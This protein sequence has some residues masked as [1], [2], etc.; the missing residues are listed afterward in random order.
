V[1][2][3]RVQRR[4]G[5]RDLDRGRRTEAHHLA[6]EVRRFEGHAGPGHELGN[7]SAQFFRKR[8]GRDP[9]AFLELHQ[10][11]GLVRTAGPEKDQVHRIRGRLDAHEGERSGHVLRP[12]FLGDETE[13]VPDEA[14]GALHPGPGGRAQAHLHETGFDAGKDFGAEKR[15]QERDEDAARREVSRQDGALLRESSSGPDRVALLEPLHD[16]VP[17][18][19]ALSR[20]VS[21][22]LQPRLHHRHERAREEE[23]GHHG[24]S[25]RER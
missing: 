20:L 7:P 12:H 22:A 21:L 8:R 15:R 25:H 24:E 17:P 14:L 10:E 18:A 19:P 2:S 23:R 3:V 11:N 13:N 16:L 9:G 6:H 5:D 1:L 4:A